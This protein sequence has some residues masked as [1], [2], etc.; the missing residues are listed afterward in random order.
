M[1]TAVVPS[2]SNSKRGTRSEIPQVA[3]QRTGS[4]GP[5]PA[6]RHLDCS[7]RGFEVEAA[8]GRA[9]TPDFAILSMSRLDARMACFSNNRGLG[10]QIPPGVLHFISLIGW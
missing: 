4:R 8:L 1:A 10:V 7:A 5:R 6:R 9:T 2:A 3:L